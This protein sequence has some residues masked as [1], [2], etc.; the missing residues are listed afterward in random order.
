M[1]FRDIRLILEQ[2]LPNVSVGAVQIPSTHSAEFTNK[3][4][5]TKA[6][7]RLALVPSLAQDANHILAQVPFAQESSVH[8][9][10]QFGPAQELVAR[11]LAK[12]D[13]IRV[14]LVDQLPR[15]PQGYFTVRLPSDY[16]DPSQL[17]KRFA[18]L[19]LA[20][21]Q[22]VKRVFNESVKVTLAEPGSML[23]E[24][25]LLAGNVTPILAFLGG[26]LKLGT[27]AA[28]FREAAAKAEAAKAEALKKKTEADEARARNA[29]AEA[30]AEA[31]KERLKQE[32]LRTQAVERELEIANNEL[33]GIEVIRQRL[34]FRVDDFAQQFTDSLDDATEVIPLLV[35]AVDEVA[36]LYE[37]NVTFLLQTNAS[38]EAA[39]HFPPEALPEADDV[40]Q[41]GPGVKGLLVAHKPPKE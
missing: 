16:I 33:L 27:E 19:N 25:G 15:E 11:F 26:L 34:K 39:V 35:K 4:S 17:V 30:D 10:G 20:F 36:E 6:L 37:E 31:A 38:P 24:L 40:H 21:E 18:S 2:E 41:L 8:P 9:V 1:R 29:E 3:A 13:A 28:K 5:A 32:R 14:F 22:P 12:A 7:R 23:I